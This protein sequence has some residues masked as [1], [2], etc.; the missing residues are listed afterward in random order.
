MMRSNADFTV[1]DDELITA[2]LRATSPKAS[3][4]LHSKDLSVD[5]LAD[6]VAEATE[7][8]M[9]FKNV[10]KIDNL[11]GFNSLQRLRLDNNVIKQ[12]D[13]LH[14]LANL[15]WLDLSFNFDDVPSPKSHLNS[16]SSP[17][18]SLLSLASKRNSSFTV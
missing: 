15:T 5:T 12:I 7:I 4:T 6:M 18:G 14:H 8:Q 17:S 13:N 1:I 3:A 9:S 11:Q 16:N 2:A 10:L